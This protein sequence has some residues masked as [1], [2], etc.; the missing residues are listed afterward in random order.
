MERI[1]RGV[2]RWWRI[3]SAAATAALL[4][5]LVLLVGSAPAATRTISSS[6]HA[7][8]P[9]AS[10]GSAGS[11]TR[12]GPTD[13]GQAI[14]ITLSLVG[15]SQA[16][17]ARTVAGIADPNSPDYHHYLTPDEYAK[18][19]GASAAVQARVEDAL[20][21]AGFGVAQHSAGIILVSARGPVRQP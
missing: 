12:V 4:V 15:Q 16:D 1:T 5:A 17:L 2:G 13:P 9:T 19:F 3:P 8:K 11:P 20:R 7:G 21:S 6:A 18:R 14:S 10:G